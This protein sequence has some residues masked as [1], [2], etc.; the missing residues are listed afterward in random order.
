MGDRCHRNR[1]S[2]GRRNGQRPRAPSSGHSTPISRK[3]GCR[4][5]KDLGIASEIIRGMCKEG[6]ML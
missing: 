4:S 5:F 1:S 3:T 2:N 6:T